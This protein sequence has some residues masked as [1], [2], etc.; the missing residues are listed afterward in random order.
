MKILF[1]IDKK[2]SKVDK[3]C[4]IHYI[5]SKILTKYKLSSDEYI[6]K[7]VS[8]C[9][10]AIFDNI[11]SKHIVIYTNEKEKIKIIIGR[12]GFRIEEFGHIHN[13]DNFH[14]ICKLIL[15]Q[16]E[17]IKGLI[18][19]GKQKE[20]KMF[21]KFVSIV[22]GIEIGMF[23][24]PLK[25]IV[26]LIYVPNSF[27]VNLK[28]V[29]VKGISVNIYEEDD[30]ILFG[31]LNRNTLDDENMIEIKNLNQV[32][33]D[34]VLNNIVLKDQIEHISKEF[35]KTVSKR[36]SIRNEAKKE[37]NKEF[38]KYLMIHYF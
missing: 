29:S 6:M 15:I 10:T 31:I 21:K 26:K 13:V 24:I 32:T 8:S 17:I 19:C 37:L 2:V 12:I 22:S 38:G 20:A 7:M 23:E 27:Y 9:F 3:K 33:V 35:E 25:R 36:C 30:L 14:S 16:K 5:L 34:A 18:D 28:N 11:G 1:D 4:A